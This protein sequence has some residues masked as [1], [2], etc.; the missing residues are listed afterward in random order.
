M[1][2]LAMPIPSLF[3]IFALE[4]FILEAMYVLG[5]PVPFRVSSIPKGDPMRPALYPFLEDIIAVDGRGGAGFRSRLDQRYRTSPPFRGMLHRLT[6]LWAVPQFLVA[7]GTLAGIVLA[8]RELAYTVCALNPKVLVS[9]AEIVRR[10]IA[11]W[12]VRACYVGGDMGSGD[13]D[14]HPGGIEEREALL[15]SS[16]TDRAA[17]ETCGG[18]CRCRRYE[19]GRD[20]LVLF[21]NLV[22]MLCNDQ[23]V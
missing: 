14:S 7:G 23:T 4:M 6:M 11:A 2:M 17:A 18:C 12:L 9:E 10:L 3:F 21:Y 20:H 15:E 16:A 22:T 13:G 8:D 5:R 19:S 1:R